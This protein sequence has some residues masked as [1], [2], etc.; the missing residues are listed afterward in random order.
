MS[1]RRELIEQQRKQRRKQVTVALAIIAAF[2]MILIGGAVILNAVSSAPHPIT[3]VNNPAPP[4]AE[5]NGRA[6]GPKDAPIQVIAFVDSQCPGCALY[7][8]RYEPGVI[9]AFARTGKVRY[10]VHAL[11]FIGPESVDAAMASLCAMDQD[12]YWQMHDTIFANQWLGENSGN[13]SRATLQE[14]ASRLGLDTGSFNTCMD[15][16]KYNGTI[17]QDAADASQFG[18]NQTPTFIVNG[19][20]FTGAQ[21]ADDFRRIFAQVVP[22]VTFTQ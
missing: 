14:M 7:T 17:S 10:E 20:R 18:V 22:E 11:T 12:K 15:S 4:N 13:F 16:S 19:K 2:A 5:K 21:N 9:D 6:W 3:V 8:A 1:K